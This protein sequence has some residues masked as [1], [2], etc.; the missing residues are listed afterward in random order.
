MQNTILRSAAFMATVLLLPLML[1][2]CQTTSGDGSS[3]VSHS[4]YTPLFDQGSHLQQLIDNG[5][6]DNAITL[7]EEQT[8][9]FSV[10]ENRKKLDLALLEMANHFNNAMSAAAK[11]SLA[12]LKKSTWPAPPSDWPTIRKNMTIAMSLLDEYPSE[13]LLEDK[14]YGLAELRKV[15]QLHSSLDKRISADLQAEFDKFD[16]FNKPG[17]FLNYAKLLVTDNS[18]ETLNSLS[19]AQF[20]TDYRYF[21]YASLAT[22]L[23]QASAGDLAKFAKRYPDSEFFPNSVQSAYFRGLKHHY[24]SHHAQSGLSR[25]ATALHAEASAILDGYLGAATPHSEFKLLTAPNRP[26][27][28]SGEA[29]FPVLLVRDFS[30]RENAEPTANIDKTGIR[31]SALN[32]LDKAGLDTGRTP[33]WAIIVNPVGRSTISQIDT[34]TIQ[35]LRPVKT[36]RRLNPK[37]TSAKNAFDEADKLYQEAG[38]DEE[39]NKPIP[40]N[41]QGV[42]YCGGGLLGCAIGAFVGGVIVGAVESHR[43]KKRIEILDLNSARHTAQTTLSETPKELVTHT[44]GPYTFAR[45]TY[46]LVKG[47]SLRALT[48]DAQSKSFSLQEYRSENEK[49]VTV[50]DGV[51][52]LDKT[53][54]THFKDAM[55]PTE[56]GKLK[57]KILN[58]TLSRVI[59]TYNRTEI[60]RGHYKSLQELKELAHTHLTATA[61]AN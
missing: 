15:K 43:R 16:H 42:H 7:F 58:V 30:Q 45:K 38:G 9:Y 60:M 25:S 55:T 36:D 52:E 50:L 33:F 11:N 12:A 39:F 47:A 6:Y 59:A 5:E 19:L 49:L 31:P 17:F 35:S 48:A 3:R 54:D 56:F 24:R 1:Q 51:S 57:K 18:P 29:K 37:W 21:D 61:A 23:E 14:N 13:I 22:K 27:T 8:A 4:L 2:G 41:N 53:R 10:A 44:Y 32:E 28:G 26:A 46:R 34:K 20:T 40:Q